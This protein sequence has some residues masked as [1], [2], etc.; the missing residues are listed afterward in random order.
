MVRRLSGVP[1]GSVLGPLLFV[2]Y[3]NDLPEA[4]HSFIFMYA[5]DTKIF[6][7]V[8]GDEDRAALQRD[9]DELGRWAQEWQLRF[10]IEKC[11]VMHI[12]GKRNEK[13]VYEM[14][15]AGNNQRSQLQ[16]TE[17]EKDL[18]IWMSDTSKSSNHVAHAV[19]K[20][21][22]LLG[23]IR[24]AFTYMD[25]SLMKLLFTSVVRPHLE[26]GNVVWHPYLK[27]DIELIESVQHRATRMV[28]GLA[29]LSY[30]E[31]LK[32]LDL[33]SLVYRRARGDAIEV[34][35]YMHQI[36]KVDCSQMLPLYESV[37]MTT[38]GHSLKL[39][40]RE[41]NSQIRMNFFGMRVV[42]MW[43]SLPENVVMAS[44]VNCFKG[45][46]D[47]CSAANRFCSEWNDGGLKT[48]LSVINDCSDQH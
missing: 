18:G 15:T 7:R 12:G 48:P 4:I 25:G 19:S 47:K 28:P 14:V 21:N 42:S 33:P 37:G 27:K 10:N 46:F 31:R 23:M 9:L 5:D 40:K 30:E 39:Q 8:D 38:R 13:A 32:K 20:A 43:N 44:T 45:R 36:Y 41:C 2:C 35:K 17:E 22:Q 34:Y 6:S 3:I 11:K 26:Y 29:K 24:R 16:V 1:Q